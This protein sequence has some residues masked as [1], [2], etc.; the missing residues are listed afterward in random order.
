[1][2]SDTVQLTFFFLLFSNI[3]PSEDGCVDKCLTYTEKPVSRWAMLTLT[4]LKLRFAGTTNLCA[5]G[6]RDLK[7]LIHESSELA[8]LFFLS[9]SGSHS[10]WRENTVFTRVTS[11]Q[12]ACLLTSPGSLQ[13]SCISVCVPCY[14][15]SPTGELSKLLLGIQHW[16]HTPESHG[17]LPGEVENYNFQ[18]R[19]RTAWEVVWT[20][21][22][23]GKL[24]SFPPRELNTLHS[25]PHAKAKSGRGG[26]Q[27]LCTISSVWP[28]ASGVSVLNAC[29]DSQVVLF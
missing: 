5:Q 1:M 4:H 18:L 23:L 3:P 21:P 9:W 15:W 12:C 10:T 24:S 27:S 8:L 6:I 11:A 28:R 22:P 20:V 29:S 17:L 2:A 13:A 25:L 16:S 7:T 26:L 19:K 14:L